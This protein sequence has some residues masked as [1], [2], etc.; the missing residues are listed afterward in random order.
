MSDRPWKQAMAKADPLTF[1]TC[2]D[3]LLGF[4]M[5]KLLIANDNYSLT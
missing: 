5:V 2:S 3:N 1:G 4:L